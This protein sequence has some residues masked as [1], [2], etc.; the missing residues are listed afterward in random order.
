MRWVQEGKLSKAKTETSINRKVS[1][2]TRVVRL[3]NL[4]IA[5]EVASLTRF[6]EQFTLMPEAF[7]QEFQEV[8]NAKNAAAVCTQEG[9]GEST[10]DRLKRVFDSTVLPLIRRGILPPDI[11]L[12]IER[13][14]GN[15]VLNFS[16]QLDWF[17]IWNINRYMN[18]KNRVP[19]ATL[20][21][22]S[23]LEKTK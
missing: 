10:R 11:E 18:S 23:S 21:T 3:L 7:W 5:A 2:F 20:V 17:N 16:M 1:P 14:N 6:L 12:T 15:E 22:I 13:D 8:L 19:L 9:N 4:Y